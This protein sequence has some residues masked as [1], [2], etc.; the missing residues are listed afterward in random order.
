MQG[1]SSLSTKQFV[2][3]LLTLPL[4]F[5]LRVL[6]FSSL[7]EGIREL[8]RF[9]HLSSRVVRFIILPAFAIRTKS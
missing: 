7:V 3:S 8:V 6:H 9:G 1:E 2:T 4:S 5:S